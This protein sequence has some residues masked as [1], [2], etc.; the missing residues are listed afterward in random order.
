MSNKA[1]RRVVLVAYV[2]RSLPWRRIIRLHDRKAPVVMW[3]PHRYPSSL[4]TYLA[5]E[6]TLVKD[7]GLL[8]ALCTRG[9][10]F[11]L[12]F[13]RRI[14]SVHNCDVLYT[15]HPYNPDGVHD[16]SAG[17]LL[18]LRRIEANGN[19]LFPAVAE[20]EWW[21]NKVFMH[22]R[23]DEL[24]VHC[25]E[26]TIHELVEPLD[27]GAFTYPLLVKE[28]HSSGSLGVHK[29]SSAGELQRLADRLAADGETELLIQRL[30]DMRR[31]FRATLVGDQVV[32]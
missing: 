6:D 29:V 2:A 8:T 18:G 27:V 15:I 12:S 32:H 21:E 14:E 25:P 31:D 17:L 13:G 11:R 4:L 1:A 9:I 19:R 28:P 20:A 24:G 22:R 26:T 16:Y 30:I 7:A 10:P 5:R 3:I 23:F